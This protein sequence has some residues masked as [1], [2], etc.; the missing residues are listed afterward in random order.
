MYENGHGVA[1]SHGR[2]VKYWAKAAKQGGERER[3]RAKQMT[4]T[5]RTLSP[6]LGQRVILCGLQNTP[7]LD[8]ARGTAIDFGYRE[9]GSDGKWV[10]S[11]GRY[12]VKLDGPEG[13]IVTA[14]KENLAPDGPEAPLDRAV[15]IYLRLYGRVDRGEVESFDA[16]PAA[17]LEEMSQLVLPVFTACAERGEMKA[18][19]S[20]PGT[21]RERVR[22]LTPNP[23][24]FTLP[25]LPGLRL[26]VWRDCTEGSSAG[27]RARHEGGASR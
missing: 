26:R 7:A 1:H 5:T 12:A 16:L 3:Q 20:V 19:V 24:T 9:Q 15:R 10:G 13:K 23:A 27:V 8:G 11:S 21:L 4:K 22:G 17:E 18:Q 2:A 25:V 6:F 14:R